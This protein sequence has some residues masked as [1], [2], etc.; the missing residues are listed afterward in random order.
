[1]RQKNTGKHDGDAPR[2]FNISEG[3]IGKTKR[4]ATTHT[5]MG[6][7]CGNRTCTNASTRE[8]EVD[9]GDAISPRV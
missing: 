8:R 6:C 9:F 4:T 1:M 5:D 3:D 2:K 7:N